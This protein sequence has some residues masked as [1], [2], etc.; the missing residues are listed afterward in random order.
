MYVG[1]FVCVCAHENNASVDCRTR[2]AKKAKTHRLLN[3][4]ELRKNKKELRKNKGTEKVEDSKGTH[5][6][7][8][9]GAAAGVVAMRQRRQPIHRQRRRTLVIDEE[10]V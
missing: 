5:Q 9:E 3:K 2:V 1:V 7:S 6:N 8:C 4:K 10:F